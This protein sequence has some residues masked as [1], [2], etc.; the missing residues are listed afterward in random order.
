M[1]QVAPNVASM[2]GMTSEP[3]SGAE[4]QRLREADATGAGVQMTLFEVAREI[5]DRLTRIFLPDAAGTPALP[6]RPAGLRRGRALA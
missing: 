1:T 6:W 5:S 4:R 3:S 2:T